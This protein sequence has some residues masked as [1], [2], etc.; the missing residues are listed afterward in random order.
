LFPVVEWR[1]INQTKGGTNVKSKVLLS[2]FIGVM[3]ALS[4]VLNRSLARAASLE[5]FS[6]S[7]SNLTG[8]P[9]S[10]GTCPN[11]SGTCFT[12][13]FSGPVSKN[14]GGVVSG[15]TLEVTV[16]GDDTTAVTAPAIGSC[17]AMQGSGEIKSGGGANVLKFD[18][19]GWVC[20]TVGDACLV[21]PLSFSIINGVGKFAV[22]TGTGTFN[23]VSASCFASPDVQVTMRGVIFF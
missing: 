20:D 9:V 5:N 1:A 7:A 3:V 23:G 16:N 12:E 18:L 14:I 10:F 4:A 17:Y 21:G 6:A 13:T 15:G 8:A 2:V 22:A 11:G 19:Q